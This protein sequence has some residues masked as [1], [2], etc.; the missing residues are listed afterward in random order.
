MGNKHIRVCHHTAKGSKSKSKDSK[1]KSKGS[2]KSK[3][4]SSSGS[5]GKSKSSAGSDDGKSMAYNYPVK[6]KNKKRVEK[7]D[8]KIDKLDRDFKK[9]E[10][11]TK[12]RLERDQRWDR[13]VLR[14][15]RITLTK[16]EDLDKGTVANTVQDI[17][18]DQKNP[19]KLTKKEINDH[20]AKYDERDHRYKRARR[21]AFTRVAKGNDRIKGRQLN[22]FIREY[23]KAV[24]DVDADRYPVGLRLLVVQLRGVVVLPGVR[25]VRWRLRRLRRLRL[26]RRRLR[27]VLL[28]VSTPQWNE[29]KGGVRGR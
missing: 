10:R 2:S 12:K 4:K 14:A 25:L 19:N 24:V 1:S 18:A 16:V 11:R 27:F 29:K 23:A 22:R 17:V 21:K 8:S 13:E 28:I 5:K 20:N 7:L 6:G 9:D 26:V 3:G 15:K